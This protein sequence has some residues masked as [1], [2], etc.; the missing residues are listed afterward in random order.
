MAEKY[1]VRQLEK[2]CER[3]IHHGCWRLKELRYLMEQDAQNNVQ[4][5]FLEEHPIIRPLSQ[6]QDLLAPE[7]TFTQP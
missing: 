6:Y 1:P 4:T 7:E 3:A 5:D 2:A